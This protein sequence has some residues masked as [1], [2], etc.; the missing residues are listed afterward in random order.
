MMLLISLPR[1]KIKK[2]KVFLLSFFLVS[3][4]LDVQNT[5][6]QVLLSKAAA[7]VRTNFILPIPFV[8]FF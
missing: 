6:V 5:F 4:R 7:K 2:N 1:K 3:L 8:S